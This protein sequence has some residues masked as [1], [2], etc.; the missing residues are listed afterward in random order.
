MR[1]VGYYFPD[2]EPSFEDTQVGMAPVRVILGGA[3][4]TLEHYD[5]EYSLRFATVEYLHHFEL[6]SN[7]E[8]V[9]LGPLVII[10]RWD[11]PT[12]ESV[13]FQLHERIPT[14]GVKVG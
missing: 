2:G 5:A 11:K 1:I 6:P 10:P 3:D 13:L 9:A 12:I 7:L 4:A 8:Y 14:F